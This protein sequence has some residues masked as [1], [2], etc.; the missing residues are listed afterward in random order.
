MSVFACEFD[1]R[2]DSESLENGRFP[3]APADLPPV[4][5]TGFLA[6]MAVPQ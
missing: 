2:F 6:N 4:I 3:L 5:L 1:T